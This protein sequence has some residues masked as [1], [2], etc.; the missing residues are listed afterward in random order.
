MFKMC[1]LNNHEKNINSKN[2]HS[3]DYIHCRKN[4]PNDNF[5]SSKNTSS[6]NFPWS[7]NHLN[8]EY[9]KINSNY[10]FSYSRRN[11]RQIS[12]SFSKNHNNNNL[13]SKNHPRDVHFSESFTY[14]TYHS[15][16]LPQNFRPFDHLKKLL[17]KNF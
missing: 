10:T 4:H 15:D 1:S 8:T 6:D 11:S 16:S 12:H 7:N 2:N 3:I 13:T 5:Q 14:K 17:K 9:S